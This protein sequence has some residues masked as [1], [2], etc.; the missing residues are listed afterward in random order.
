M[1]IEIEDDL[2]VFWKNQKYQNKKNNTT[3]IF[4]INGL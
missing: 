4:I 3:G 2:S 1:P